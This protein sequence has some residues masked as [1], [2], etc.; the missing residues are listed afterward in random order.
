MQFVEVSR[1]SPFNEPGFIPVRGCVVRIEDENGQGV[2]YS[3]SEPGVYRADLDEPFLGVNKMYKL[4]VYTPDGEEYQSEYDSLLSCPSIDS[5]YYQIEWRVAEDPDITYQGIQFYVDVKGKADNSRNFIWKLEETYEYNARYMIQYFWNGES[6]QGFL[7]PDQSLFK[8]FKTNSIANIYAASSRYLVGNE[9][10]G[11]PLNFVSAGTPKLKRKYGL[12]VSQYSLSD[13]AF[14]YWE[15]MNNM[16]SETGGLYEKQ[17]ASSDGD[18]YKVNDPEEQILGFFYTSQEREKWIIT[19]NPG[20]TIQD[21]YCP[22][23]TV[24]ELIY[25]EIDLY[26]IGLGINAAGMRVGPPYGKST[27]GCFDCRERGGS[28]EPPLYWLID[29]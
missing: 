18:I 2:N 13:D 25:I 19:K 27:S 6:L 3:E 29:E 9:L 15:K 7:P 22:I 11:Y 28:L 14:L 24:E 10:N 1:A 12:V 26:M 16:I 17:P 23:D 8:C 21:Y 4:F 5:L 20:F